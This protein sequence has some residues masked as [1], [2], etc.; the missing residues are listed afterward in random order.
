M[1]IRLQHEINVLKDRVDK[2]EDMVALLKIEIKEMVAP[3][4]KRG[5]PKKESDKE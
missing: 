1:S 2:L 5:R 3:E 4:T